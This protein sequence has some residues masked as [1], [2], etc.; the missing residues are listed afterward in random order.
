[1]G[2]LEDILRKKQLRWFGHLHR[3]ESDKNGETSYALAGYRKDWWSP[4]TEDL[5]VIGLIWESAQE[6]VEDRLVW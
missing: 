1:M 4:V 5:N 6:L 3:M 2:K